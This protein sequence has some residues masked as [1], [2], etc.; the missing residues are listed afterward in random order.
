MLGGRPRACRRRAYSGGVTDIGTVVRAKGR[1]LTP[2]RSR[3]LAVIT[4]RGHATP[5]EIVAAIATDGGPP[6]PAST[7][8]RNLE[9]LQQIGLVAHTHVDHR[10]PSYHLADH[11][12]HIHLACRGCGR[13]EEVP[14]EVGREFA[15]AVRA[16]TGFV[17]EMTH[18]AVHGRCAECHRKEGSPTP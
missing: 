4:A 14:A 1:R 11:A 2:Q 5:E 17:A 9:A 18:A 13:V 8:Y 7:V 6:M 10:V 12:T 15:E 3:V 16:R